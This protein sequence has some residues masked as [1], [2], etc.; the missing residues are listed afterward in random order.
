[1]P[2]SFEGAGDCHPLARCPMLEAEAEA[3]A[4]VEADLSTS[5]LE[6]QAQRESNARTYARN[7]GLV[8][9]RAEGIHV[10]DT[11]G[12]RY[13]DCLAGAGSLP[14]GHNHPVVKTAIL[15]AMELNVPMQTL[16]L[17]T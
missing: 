15:E 16:D 2:L 6:R 14:L 5:I 3:E 10:I 8:L 11:N 17:A 12:R 4:E 13:I 9:A 7:L 1:M